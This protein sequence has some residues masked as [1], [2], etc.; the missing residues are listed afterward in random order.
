MEADDTVVAQAGRWILYSSGEWEFKMDT[1]RQGRCLRMSDLKCLVDLKL[2]VKEIFKMEKRT[3][4]VELSYMFEDKLAVLRG[5]EEGPTQIKDDWQFRSFKSLSLGDKSV[6]LFVCFRETDGTIVGREEEKLGSLQ[7]CDDSRLERGSSSRGFGE[8]GYFGG[9]MS[10][11]VERAKTVDEDKGRGSKRT[12]S[13]IWEINDE[14]LV[15]HVEE[16]E[17]ALLGEDGKQS[18][19]N[20][21]ILLEHVQAVELQLFGGRELEAGKNLFDGQDK[22][23]DSCKDDEDISDGSSVYSQNS[24]EED[25][26]FDGDKIEDM[27]NKGDSK[28]AEK[29]EDSGDDDFIEHPPSNRNKGKE[30]V[31]WGAG[32]LFKGNAKRAL[33]DA[34]KIG[35]TID[36]VYGYADL[37]PMFADEEM[38][39][40]AAHVDLTKED[41]NMFSKHA[42]SKV[43]AAL[44][45]ANYANAYCG[46]RARDLLE[47]ILTEHNVR[48]SYWKAWKVKE[49]A[50]VTAQGIDES[51]YALLPVYLHV[52]KLANPGTVY[53]LETSIPEVYPKAHHGFCLVHIRRNVKAKYLKKGGLPSLVWRAGSMYRKKDFDD[54]YDRIKQR[55]VRCWEF[56]E[57]IGVEN[58]S[59]AYFEGERY[60]LMSS[61]IAES[62]NKA[63]LPARGSP[64]LALIEFIRKMLGRW[65]ETRRKRI[66]RTV[67]DNPIAVERELLKRF[68][69]GLGM[70][71]LAVGRWDFEVKPKEGGHFHVSLEK[72]TCSSLEFQKLNLPCTHA[73]AAAHKRRFEYK[74]LVGDMHKIKMW[75]PTVEGAILP[76]QDLAEVEV[77][78]DIRVMCLMPPQTKRPPER[79]PKLRIH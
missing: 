11:V 34:A 54:E 40:K 45:R 38:N 74:L 76:V 60:N 33:E 57:G 25:G 68:K 53:K 47:C 41:D 9:L 21:D 26:D 63:L 71:V 50:V 42:T 44:L 61:N 5:I 73:M 10:A 69:G 43:V 6:N 17:A 52:L 70:A 7:S 67:G 15:R 35:I 58:W 36:E 14:D 46:P 49:L 39:K 19:I 28:T 79:P 31:V 55:N 22:G 64:V 8:V 2:K 72:R 37:E 30:V 59:R 77:P 13:D 56:L 16:V 65:F 3:V 48:V 4:F 29:G 66:A 20:D 18:E 75:Q 24:G 27:G 62:L 23:T 12:V 51:S 78:E 1:F 32:N